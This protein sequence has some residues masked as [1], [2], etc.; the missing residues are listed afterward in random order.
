MAFTEFLRMTKKCVIFVLFVCLSLPAPLHPF[1]FRVGEKLEFALSWIG[2]PAGTA[3]LE[4]RSREAY[5]GIDAYS[6]LSRTW[7]NSF[8]STFYKVDDRIEG[9]MNANDLSGLMFK[10]RQREGGYRSDKEIL[11]YP[12][13]NQVEFTKNGKKSFFTVPPATRDSM[14]AFFYLRTKKLTVGKDIVIDTFSN[15]KLLKVVV[16]ILKR[17][18]IN[19]GA[20]TFSTVKVQPLIKHNDIF[21]SKGDIFI[22]LTDDEFKIP[23]KIKVQVTIGYVKAELK[24]ADP[25]K[26]Q[27]K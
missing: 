20:V 22:W 8:V 25:D 2:I 24:I 15:G 23:V 11:F 17:E 13:E 10:I 26:P 4:V 12:E 16:K 1:P 21:K 7:S 19:L 9:F 3:T 14:S 6:F 5:K 27:K 18:R